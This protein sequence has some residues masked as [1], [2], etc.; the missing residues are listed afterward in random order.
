MSSKTDN[1]KFKTSNLKGY[2]LV[3]FLKFIAIFS[4]KSA[5][6]IGKIIGLIFFMLPSREKNT[7]RKNIALCL[8][9]NSD[10]EKELLLKQT[11]IHSGM[12]GAEMALAW[13]WPTNRC[14]EQIKNIYHEDIINS[15][16]SEGRGVICVI[17][18]LGNWEFISHYLG[19]NYPGVAMYKPAKIA[20]LD[21]LVKNSR[22]NAGIEVTPTNARGVKTILKHLKAGGTTFILADQEPAYSG[23]VFVPFF[24]VPALTMTLVYKLSQKTGARIIA[25]YVVRRENNDGF[26]VKHKSGSNKLYSINEIEAVT[27]MNE[28]IQSCIM[29]A[30]EQYQWTYKRFKRR[31]PDTA[32]LY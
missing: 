32:R 10:E 8:A 15:A 1:S 3:G 11:F 25:S 28:L 17:P 13:L 2:F 22:I 5:Q 9:D 30:P 29:E 23:G 26:D 16:L 18:H 20:L 24:G 4:L 6:N 19:H 14:Y 27:A 31:P 21:K 7:A 12:L